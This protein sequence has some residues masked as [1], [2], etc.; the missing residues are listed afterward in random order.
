MPPSR[1][2]ECQRSAWQRSLK[3]RWKCCLDFA[4]GH[5]NAL[6]RLDRARLVDVQH[7]VELIG[8]PRVEVVASA[9]GFRKVNDS[10]RA[11]QARF[12]EKSC[13]RAPP[14]I[15]HEARD[16]DLVEQRFVTAR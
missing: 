9:L 6:E 1:C 8:E 4:G 11:L 16:V 13:E 15:E 7:G 3:T 12:A 5:G 10:D 14:K 2:A